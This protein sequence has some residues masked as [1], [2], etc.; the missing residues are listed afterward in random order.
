MTTVLTWVAIAI[1]LLLAILFFIIPGYS[2][3]GFV[4]LGAAGI[5]LCY[6]L[7]GLMS[8]NHIM[9]AKVLKTVLSTILC[10]GIIASAI[11]F[12]VIQ[13]AAKGEPGAEEEYLVVLGAGVRGTT[14][15]TIL[16]TRINAAIDY[17]NEHPDVICVVSGGQGNNEDISEAKCMFDHIAA[18]G[19][20]PERIWMEDQSTSTW[21]NF[22]FSL[23]LIE[24]K[25]GERPERFAV[26]SN[27]FH[28]YRAGLVAE[29]CGITVSGV[30]A[31][32]EYV[33]LWINYTLREIPATWYYIIFGGN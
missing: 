9:A 22:Q 15:S 14:P 21:E 24:E 23:D 1:F 25:T 7:L 4:C 11:T 32:T 12:G 29:K 16:R 6:F 31:K 33:S 2:F 27:E 13:K 10:I 3:S 19:I 26:L 30:P 8:R 28:L 5:I 17:L 18:A 20:D